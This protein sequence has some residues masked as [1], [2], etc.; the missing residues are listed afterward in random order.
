MKKI[1]LLISILSLC[2]FLT[3]CTNQNDDEIQRI[4][5]LINEPVK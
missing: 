1:I 4:G 2:L 3:G 5:N